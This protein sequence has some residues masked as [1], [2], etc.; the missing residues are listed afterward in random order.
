MKKETEILN[1]I[2]NLP[3]DMIAIAAPL[4]LTDIEQNKYI[5]IKHTII[6][7]STSVAAVLLLTVVLSQTLPINRISIFNNRVADNDLDKTSTSFTPQVEMGLCATANGTLLRSGAEPTVISE[8][9]PIMSSVPAM[10]IHLNY[11]KSKDVTIRVTSSIAN[12]LR[13]YN[14]VDGSMWEVDK[15]ATT[16]ELPND[17]YFFYNSFTKDINDSSNNNNSELKNQEEHITLEVI[18]DGNIIETRT[19]SFIYEDMKTFAIIN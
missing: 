11:D 14:I 18:K 10:R 2:G 16:I 6:R 4:D 5:H 7:L 17:S 13:T 12:A 1:A 9:S 3:E 15:I 19:I 8:Y